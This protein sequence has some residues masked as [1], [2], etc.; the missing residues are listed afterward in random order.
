MFLDHQVQRIPQSSLGYYGEWGWALWRSR[1]PK[2]YHRD[3]E[4][5]LNKY[6]LQSYRLSFFEHSKQRS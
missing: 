4:K 1:Q 3:F 2:Y 5:L 6:H